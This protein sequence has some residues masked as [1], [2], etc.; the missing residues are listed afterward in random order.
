MCAYK[1]REAIHLIT[2]FK[3]VFDDNGKDLSELLQEWINENKSHI[4]ANISKQS[5]N[6][7]Q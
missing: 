2:D 1:F 3:E 7:T 5:Y 4:V 6:S